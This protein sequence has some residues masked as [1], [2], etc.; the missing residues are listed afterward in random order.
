MRLI[1]Y[2]NKRKWIS[3]IKYMREAKNFNMAEYNNY[4]SDIAL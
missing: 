4:D 1:I 3:D 2:E